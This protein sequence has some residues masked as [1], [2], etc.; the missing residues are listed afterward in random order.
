MEMESRVC[1]FDF[2]VTREEM[3][4]FAALSGDRSFVHADDDFARRHGFR[5]AIVYGGILL[6]K[7]SHCLG[8]HLPGPRGVSMEWTIRYHSPLYVGD[9]AH[10]HAEVTHVSEAMRTVEIAYQVTLDGRKIASGTAH[11]RV[12]AD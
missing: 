9:T 1:D 12:L 5:E 11:S 2:H 6:A 8:T 3:E 10:F 7:L 4:A